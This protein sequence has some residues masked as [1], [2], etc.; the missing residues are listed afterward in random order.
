MSMGHRCGRCSC[1]ALV[2]KCREA[3]P[4]ALLFSSTQ[5][6]SSEEVH[7]CESPRGRLQ[8]RLSACTESSSRRQKPR[9]FDVPSVGG[10]EG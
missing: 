10:D 6:S 8:D 5:C 2:W 9:R 1:S 4:I 3:T 7:D